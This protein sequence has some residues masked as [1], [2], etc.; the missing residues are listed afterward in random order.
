MVAIDSVQG[1]ATPRAKKNGG[2]RS[3]PLIVFVVL[4][5]QAVKDA[6]SIFT[7]GPMVDDS[8]TPFT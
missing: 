2:D 6:G 4:M 7:P 1:G 8:E 3:P 5:D